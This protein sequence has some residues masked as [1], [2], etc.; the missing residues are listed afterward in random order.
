MT[1]HARWRA[2]A[3]P[4]NTPPQAQPQGVAVLTGHRYA[5]PDGRDAQRL[6]VG[7][8][9]QRWPEWHQALRPCREAQR[10]G[11]A[12]AAG[13]QPSWSGLPHLF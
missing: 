1:K 4:A 6:R 13:R 11:R 9:A 12:G 5:R 3:H 8:R 2:H 10:V 7:G